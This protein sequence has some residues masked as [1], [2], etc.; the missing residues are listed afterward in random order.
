MRDLESLGAAVCGVSVDATG[1]L[2]AFA[3][4][5]QLPFA[6]LSD[7]G[8]AVAARYGSLVD[9]GVVK[10]ARRNTF[11]IDPAGRVACV[12]LG[13]NPARNAGEV[14]ARLRRERG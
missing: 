2:A 5:Y 10:F 7:R 14:V 6:L 3:R 8:G 13:V 1:R 9:L 12:Y 4:R 11:L